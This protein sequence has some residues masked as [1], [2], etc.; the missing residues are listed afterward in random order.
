VPARVFH[1]EWVTDRVSQVD[2]VLTSRGYRNRTVPGPVTGGR[3][4][5]EAR[6]KSLLY[7]IADG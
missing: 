2:Q 7:L 6:Q 5:L 1:K 4:E 3:N